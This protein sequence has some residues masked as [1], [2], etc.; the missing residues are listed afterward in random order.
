M[1]IDLFSYLY[2]LFITDGSLY[3]QDRNR[4]RISLEVVLKDS[5]L[6]EKM[7]SLIPQ[8]SASVRTRDTNFKEQNSSI[9]FS[10]YQ[11]EFRQQFINAGFPIKDKTNEANT[12]QIEYSVRDFWRG[13]IDGDGSLGFTKDSQPFVSFATKSEYLKNEY[14]RFLKNE[15]GIIKN[16]NR[17]VRDSIYNIVVKNEDAVKLVELIY[18]E[19]DV[20]HLGRKFLI[21]NEIQ[22]WRRTKEKRSRRSFTAE[23][24][25]FIKN[26]SVEECV[27]ALDR[28]S[29]SIKAKKHRLE[30]T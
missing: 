2:G 9:I 16:V 25:D 1:T 23:E 21:S 30:S 3:L 5:E 4:G 22:K 19:K 24:I 14:L 7:T 11:L 27:L 12:P 28:T 29:A 20:L 13:V 26:H 18:S 6:I 10:N 8:S 17:N 15:F